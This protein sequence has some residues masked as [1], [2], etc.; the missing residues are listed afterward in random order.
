M[1]VNKRLLGQTQPVRLQ[2]ALV[3]GLGLLAGGLLVAQAYLLSRIISRV[4]LNGQGLHDVQALLLMLLVVALLRAGLIWSGEVLAQQIAGR[5]KNELRERLTTHLLALG[6]NYTRRERSGELATT[7]VEGIEALDTYFGQYVP[8]LALAALVPLTILVFVFP[9]DFLTG[10]V[11]L[12]TAPLIPIFMVLIGRQAE[13]MT[14]RQWT[15][16]S[17]MSAHFLDVLQG[18][19]TLKMLNRSR[20]QLEIIARISE[21]FGQTTL[22]VLRVAFLSALVLELVATLSTAVVAVE[23]G[24]RLLYGRLIFE[25]ALFVLILAPEFYAPLRSLSARFHTAMSGAS[26]ARRIFEILDTPLPLAPPLLC[27]SAP[28]LSFAAPPAIHFNDVYYTYESEGLPAL[29]GLSFHLAPGQRVALV[30]PSGAGKSTVAYLLLRFAEPSQGLI[31]INDQPLAVL[32]PAAWRTQVAWVPQSPYLFHASVAD[33]IRLAR[34]EASLDQIEWAAGQACAAEFI[35]ALPQGY[36]TRIGERGARL[37]GGQAQRLAL[38]RAFLRDAPL[39]ILDEA[40]AHLDPEHEACLQEALIRLLHGRTAL[41]IAHRLNT[42]Y[43]M[44]QILVM[45]EGRV[46]EAGTHASLQQQKGVYQKM[47]EAYLA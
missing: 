15:G 13:A 20:D 44:D 34:P 40:T 17:R 9:L 32:D 23:V 18:L 33:N 39:L 16:L 28:L 3:I 37:S 10:L 27:S 7:A 22:G 35:E 31:T 46:V 6:P 47:V 24:L 41:I 2:L 42:V 30:G 38:A 29:N 11:L 5:I 36:D 43:S 19:P 4:F 14:Q 45:V 1:S 12:L 8:H 26:A 25:Q 21:R